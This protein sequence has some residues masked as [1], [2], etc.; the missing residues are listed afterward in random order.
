MTPNA[1][2][3][4]SKSIKIP[5]L[6]T[7]TIVILIVGLFIALSLSTKTFLSYSNIY[8]IVFGVS[9]QFFALI[10]FTY[11][12]I[13]G[14][15]DLSIGAVYGFA[16]AF[17]GILVTTLNMPFVP[18]LF[19]TLVVASLI[20]FANGFLV[21]RYG[22]NSMMVTIGMMAVLRGLISIM[23]GI[24]GAQMFPPVYRNFIKFK[25]FGIH[26]SIIVFVILVVVLEILLQ[27]TSLFQRMYYIGHNINTA[28]IYGVQTG[29]IK[30]L[31]FL[32]SG[33]TAGF[34]GILATSRITH[35]FPTI[36]VGMEF[37]VVTAAVLGGASLYGG[38]GSLLKFAL[39][40]MFL[41]IVQNGMIIFGIDPYYQQV[42]MG[43]VLIVAI[44]VDTRLG[45]KKA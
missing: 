25:I 32:I 40:L 45:T 35:A 15:I 8:S 34:G 30:T 39:G 5:D 31:T 21:V 4:R 18:A 44:F 7:L 2:S 33:L 13:M 27:R 11:L 12:I 37:T 17:L 20:G 6:S 1:Q 23:I 42:F 36:G 26:W 41:A 29:R 16:G 24:L 43:V 28:R 3:I 10:G 38:R 19:L 22:L 14:E 9:F